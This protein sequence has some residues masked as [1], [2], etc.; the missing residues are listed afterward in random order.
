V[1]LTAFD[2]DDEDDED[3]Q[4]TPVAAPTPA[5]ATKAD[6]ATSRERPAQRRESKGGK[7]EQEPAE[8][9]VEFASIEQILGWVRGGKMA[10]RVDGPKAAEA[11]K[12]PGTESKRPQTLRHEVE[13]VAVTLQERRK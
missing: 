13:S 9:P 7:V 10:A 12:Q 6:G 1:G 3:D 2:E 5:A 11:Q 8:E 4:E